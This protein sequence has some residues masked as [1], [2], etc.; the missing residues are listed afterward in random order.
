[1]AGEVRRFNRV[2]HVREVERRITQGELADRMREEESILKKVDDIRTKRDTALS[3]FCSG[4]DGVVSPQQMWFERQS[5]DVLESNLEGGRQEL[6]CCRGKIEETKVVLVEKH[7]NVQL[8]EKYVEKLKDRDMK[9]MLSDEQNNLD[10]I[11]SMRYR[12]NMRGG[13]GV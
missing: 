11:T 8:M 6:E 4:R 10:D 7:R 13:P 9:K 1:M 12:M 3:D 5:I 2:L